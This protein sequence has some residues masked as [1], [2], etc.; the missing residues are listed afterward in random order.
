MKITKLQLRR[1]IK[2]EKARLLQEGIGT[3]LFRAIE[4]VET[5]IITMQNAAEELEIQ[6]SVT[7]GDP[8]VPTPLIDE[9]RQDIEDLET[10]VLTFLGRISP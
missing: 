9:L 4:A 6:H 10:I 2:E 1:I 8:S 5:A 3:G 7:T